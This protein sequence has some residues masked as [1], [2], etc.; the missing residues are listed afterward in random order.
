MDAYNALEADGTFNAMKQFADDF[1]AANAD[2]LRYYTERWVANPIHNWS[3]RWEYPY[4]FGRLREWAESRPPGPARVLDAGS[5]LTFFPHFAASRLEDTDFECGDL[6]ARLIGDAKRLAPPAS[7][8]VGY[9]H[10]NIERNA[11]PDGAF[12]VIYCISVLEHCAHPGEP[13]KGFYRTLKPGG[14]LILTIDISLD[15][16]AEIPA[17]LAARLVGILSRHFAPRAD[18][19][20]MLAGFKPDIHLSTARAREID[21][22]LLPWAPPRFHHLSVFCMEFA[23]PA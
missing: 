6:D 22:T 12:D 13:L 21:P 19:L 8:R 15:G 16:K 2:A 3:R 23:K 1:R 17:A 5:G 10:L 14:R 20:P 7:G 18:Y 4:V 9:S 11:Y